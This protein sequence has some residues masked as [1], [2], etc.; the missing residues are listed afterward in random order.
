MRP[1]YREAVEQDACRQGQEKQ[2]RDE[3]RAAEV[4]LLGEQ[5]EDEEDHANQHQAVE[6]SL[7]H[8][9]GRYAAPAHA[10]PPPQEVR[11]VDLP[12]PCRKDIVDRV[13]DENRCHKLPQGEHLLHPEYEPPTQGSDGKAG[14]I[15]QYRGYQPSWLHGPQYA[16]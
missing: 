7:D 16:Q 8:D 10:R 11:P 15:N 2:A 13:P 3:G 9:A 1:I 6:G 12:G 14:E 5:N 4:V